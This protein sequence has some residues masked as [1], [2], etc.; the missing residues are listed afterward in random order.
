MTRRRDGIRAGTPGTGAA[1]STIGAA[2]GG[3]TIERIV[4]VESPREFR[5][6]P[7]DRSVA[8]TQELSGARQIVLLSLRGGAPIQVTASEKDVSDPQWSP[9]GR[10]LAYV[11]G[12]R[13]ARSMSTADATSSSRVIRPASRCR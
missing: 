9:D 11:R 13:S 4:A 6:R 10:R 3:L 12:E 2:T 5:L 8:M 7:G 1:T